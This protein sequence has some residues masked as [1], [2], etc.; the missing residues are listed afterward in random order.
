MRNWEL[1]LRN[2][3]RR[4]LLRV[5]KSNTIR[6]LWM[7]NLSTINKLLRLHSRKALIMFL[8]YMDPLPIDIINDL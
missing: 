4:V 5:T 7:L 3:K 8:N 6:M 2:Q 1:C